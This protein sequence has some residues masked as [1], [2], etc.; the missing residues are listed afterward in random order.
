MTSATTSLT[1]RLVDKGTRHIMEY[2]KELV[3]NTLA[4]AW[5][6][7]L[8]MAYKVVDNIL[9]I[10]MVLVIM[11]QPAVLSDPAAN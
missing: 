1:E 9:Y 5:N 11:L 10:M 8:S 4:I 2:N 3:K 7:V 6:D